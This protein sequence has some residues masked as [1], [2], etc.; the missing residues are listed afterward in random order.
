MK[1]LTYSTSRNPLQRI[2]AI[3]LTVGLAILGFMFSAVVFTVL[4]VMGLIGWAFLWWKTRDIRKQFQLMQS[5]MQSQ[6]RDE[7]T[8]AG[9]A[10][11]DYANTESQG[12]TIEGEA[13]RVDEGA[14]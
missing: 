1:T 11:A 14:R 4:L 10:Q 6:M 13:V 7:R 9:D 2:F 8:R 12:R 3:I 5:Q